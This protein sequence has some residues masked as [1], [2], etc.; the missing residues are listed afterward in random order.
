MGDAFDGTGLIAVYAHN[1]ET[2]E[3]AVANGF[4]ALVEGDGE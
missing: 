4:V 2:V 1:Q 3:W